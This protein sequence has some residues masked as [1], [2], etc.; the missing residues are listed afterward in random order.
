MTRLWLVRHGRAAA[1]WNVDPDPD[2]D[3]V[4]REQADRVAAP[5]AL[6]RASAHGVEVLLVIDPAE[7]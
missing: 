2:L 5:L 7:R 3:E 1:G 6:V 4:G